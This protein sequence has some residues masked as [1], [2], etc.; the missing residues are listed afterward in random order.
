MPGEEGYPT[1]LPSRLASFYERAGA[2]ECLGS[3]GRVGSVTIVGAVSPPGGDFSEPVTQSTMRVT[4]ALWALDYPLAH[5]RHYPA[6]NWN[7]SYS[8]YTERLEA[9]Q[10]EHVGPSWPRLRERLMELME[11]EAELQEVVQLV[12]PDSLQESDRLTL[13]ASRMLRDGF[14]Q[15]N[16]TSEVDASC[17]LEKQNGM[18][19]LLFQYYD[20]GA[21]ALARKVSLERILSLPEREELARLR[22]IPSA[23]FSGKSGEIA[24]RLQ[25]AFAGLTKQEGSS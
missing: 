12:G 1:Y 19:E 3:D 11:K 25:A 5:S 24:G 4:G 14:L 22:E 8:L 15:Q 9:W 23:D 18:L 10:K 2:A 6:I 16:A 7:R 21:A 13:E 20:L 17:P